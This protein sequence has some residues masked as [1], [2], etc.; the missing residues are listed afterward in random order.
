M[1]ASLITLVLAVLAFATALNLFLVLR[2]AGVVF[3]PDEPE[4]VAPLVGQPAPR[5]EASRQSDGQRIA[6]DD[7]V[8]HP[9]VLVFLSAGCSTCRTKTA[10]L[11]EILPATQQAG[12]E[13]WIVAAD[14]VHDMAGLTGDS[15]LADRA[16][17]MDPMA[18][19]ALNP[20]SA[21]P[22]Y[23]FIDEAMIVRAGN[24]LGDEDWRAFVGEMRGWLIEV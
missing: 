4:P 22:L 14:D 23:I 2:I 16:L 8:G 5:F 12:V 9:L 18:R 19:K 7:L 13:L 21:A 11:L 6:S 10:E 20:L 1:S 15:P 17:A 24:Y 3:P